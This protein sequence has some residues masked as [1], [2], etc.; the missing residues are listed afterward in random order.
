MVI[1]VLLK[2]VGNKRIVRAGHEAAF[3]A[4]LCCLCKVA[5]LHPDDQLG[6]VFKVFDKL[7]DLLMLVF[8]FNVMLRVITTINHYQTK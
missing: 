1:I 7:V 8:V 4:F 6:I 2:C 3:A 5:A